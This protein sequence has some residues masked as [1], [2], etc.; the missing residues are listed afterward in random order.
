MHM[1]SLSKV[2]DIVVRGT[3][4]I[5]KTRERELRLTLLEG[6]DATVYSGGEASRM[7]Q[8]PGQV[9]FWKTVSCVLFVVC[10]ALAAWTWVKTTRD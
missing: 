2:D 10:L 8:L 1:K 6:T 4:V 3:S 7:R 5:N 9:Q